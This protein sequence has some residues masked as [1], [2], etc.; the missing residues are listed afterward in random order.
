MSATKSELRLFFAIHPDEAARDQL[1]ENAWHLGEGSHG[2]PVPREN[3]HMTLLFLGEQP[4]DQLTA[5]YEAAARVRCHSFDVVCDKLRYMDEQ[6]LIW[7]GVSTPPPDLGRL[8]MALIAELDRAEVTFDRKRF[9][10]HVTLV[11]RAIG[12]PANPLD[13]V[14]CRWPVQSFSL[15]VSTPGPLGPR[16][17]TLREWHLLPPRPAAAEEIIKHTSAVSF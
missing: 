13:F 3:L 15:L 14:A 10:P 16:Y 17:H 6:H 11:R 2:R 12:A 1:A 5:I 9:K 8:R 4:A 7:T